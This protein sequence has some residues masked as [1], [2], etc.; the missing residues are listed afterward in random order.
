MCGPLFVWTGYLTWSAWIA[1][2]LLKLAAD[3]LLYGSAAR[4]RDLLRYLPL[5]FLAQPIYLTAM[6]I[7]GTRPRFTW[8]T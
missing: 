2:T 5:W 6:A 8:K 1:G 7:W 3:L 4:R